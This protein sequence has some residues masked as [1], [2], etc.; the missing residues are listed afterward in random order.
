MRFS[1]NGL[2]SLIVLAAIASSTP[3]ASISVN[4]TTDG[5][6]LVPPSGSPSGLTT[7][8]LLYTEA[9]TDGDE[10]RSALE[11][12]ISGIGSGQT[13]TS[14]TLRLR[15]QSRTF[16]EPTLLLY[17]YTGNGSLQNA[18]FLQTGNQLHATST[19][20]TGGYAF[21][22]VTNF[23]QSVY[24]TS[25]YAGFLVRNNVTNSQ[26]IYYNA[27]DPLAA[28]RPLLD[29]TSTAS[30]PEPSTWVTVTGL[31]AS[32]IAAAGWRRRSHFNKHALS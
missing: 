23:I 31:A 9:Q 7:T 4:P 29:V 14:A 6:A 24:G 10:L 22:D 8:G 16:P 18:D 2:F 30:V 27:E 11:F 15:L 17:G 5:Y 26:A 3:A 13:I 28:N 32:G 12:D 25:S 19:P 20:A 1:C 21:L